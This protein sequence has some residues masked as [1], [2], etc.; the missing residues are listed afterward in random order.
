MHVS[1]PVLY[2]LM[3]VAVGVGV[4]LMLSA[5]RRGITWLV[6]GIGVWIAVAVIGAQILPLAVQKLIVEPN[7][8]TKEQA[9]LQ[10]NIDMTR[11]AYGLADIDEQQFPA[12]AAATTQEIQSSTDTINNV[13]LWDP[14]TLRTA[15]QQLQTIRP[16]FQFLD[17]DVDRYLLDGVYRQVMLSA[18]ELNSNRLPGDA[19]TWVNGRLQFTH[20]YG[21]TVAAVTETEPDGSPSFLVD[22]IPLQGEPEHRPAGAVLRGAARPLHHRR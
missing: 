3:A 19:Q 5:F 12:T 20:G 8:V 18:R 16:L 1:L 10:R 14:E 4:L 13:R 11:Y 21:Y 6:A 22:N 9:Y 2:A 15:L 17:V 7:E